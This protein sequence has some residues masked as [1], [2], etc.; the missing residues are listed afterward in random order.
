M[1]GAALLRHFWR[2]MLSSS[3]QEIFSSYL[4]VCDLSVEVTKGFATGSELSVSI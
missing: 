4:T 3:H 1:M 2:S